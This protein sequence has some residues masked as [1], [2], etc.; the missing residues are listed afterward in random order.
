VLLEYVFGCGPTHRSAARLDVRLT[1]A[2]GIKRYPFGASHDRPVLRAPPLF[3]R[4]TADRGRA[5]A[6]VDLEVRWAGRST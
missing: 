6:P 2:H 1:E 5:S 3:K 4:A